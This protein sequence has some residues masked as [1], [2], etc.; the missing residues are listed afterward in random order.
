MDIEYIYMVWR[1][2][3]VFVLLVVFGL[4][5]ITLLSRAYAETIHSYKDSLGYTHYDGHNLKGLSKT[6]SLGYTHSEF[7][8][9]GKRSK[10]LSKTDSR[11]HTTTRCD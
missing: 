2:L 3:A 1:R 11:G 7:N 8:I 9:D 6:D 5:F 4:L 10:C